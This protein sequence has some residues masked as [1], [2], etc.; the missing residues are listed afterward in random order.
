M[1]LILSERKKNTA[2]L[3]Y[4]LVISKNDWTNIAQ[5]ME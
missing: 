4:C 2:G 5:E 1:K 3:L